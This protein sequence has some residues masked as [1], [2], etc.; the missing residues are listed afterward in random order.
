MSKAPLEARPG[1]LHCCTDSKQ[2]ELRAV[3][4]DPAGAAE[5]VAALL[6]LDLDRAAMAA[7]VDPRL[8][9]ERC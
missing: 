9:R 6:G 2:R 5:R 7:A 4:A 1:P 8:H 3:I